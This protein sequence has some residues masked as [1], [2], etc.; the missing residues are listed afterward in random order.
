M[1]ENFRFSDERFADLQLLRYRLNGF[2]TLSTRQKAFIY[3]LSKATLSGR[4][5]TTDQFGKYN[6]LIR[7][8]LEVVLTKYEGDR[9]QAEFKRLEIYLKRLWFSNG[10][11]HHYGYEKFLP[12]FSPHFFKDI[13]KQV[14]SWLPLSEG[15]TVDEL[16]EDIFPVIFDATVLP[17]RVNKNAS[18]DIVKTS[19]CN[20][21]EQVNQQE[22]E[23]F[24]AAMKDTTDEEPPSYGL[25]SKL[26][27]KGGI[28][29]EDRWTTESLYAPAIRQIVYWLNK[30]KDYAENKHQ[31]KIIDLL[32]KY[33][34]TGD[35]RVFNAYSI[36]WLKEKEGNVDFV[37]G[38][39]E[40]YG[41][42]LGIKGSWEGIVEFKDLEA[43][44][45][46]N[47]I[48]SNA[49]WFED[50]SP[51]D[52]RFKKQIVRGVTAN[53][54][55]AAMLGGDEYP[56]SAIGINLPNAD[57]IRAK[58][59]S[60]SVTIANLIEAYNHAARGNG[61]YEEFVVDDDTLQNI[62]KYGDICDSL[63]TDLHECL[64]HGSGQL[65][66]GVDSNVLGAYGDIIEEARADLFGLYYIA[67][68]KM[69]QLELLPN[70]EAYKSQYY[71][72]MMNGLMTQQVRIKSGAQIEEAHMRNRALISNWVMEH[73]CGAV[74][75]VKRDRH[76]YIKVKDY[77]ALRNLFARLLAEIQ[78]IKSEGDYIEAKNL[79]ERYGVILDPVL[80]E[81]ILQRYTKLNISPYKGFI[82]PWMKP[83]YGHK[84]EIIDIELDYTETFEHQMLRYSK[85]YGLL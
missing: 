80:H 56:S 76:T 45:R 46:T 82:N 44:K 21:Y 33:Y 14:S 20:F 18:E 54:V 16:C 3:F 57:W 72:Y 51:V 29:T 6:L 53:V 58:Y 11:Y 47:I 71:T 78:R 4:D 55:C 69:V 30:A 77:V 60:K 41:D 83:V 68:E 50:H 43:T 12:E 85:E 66:S 39:I 40:V 9:N 17:K 23:M 37:N 32:I 73:A 64:G 79:V 84:G 2:E 25:N 49:Q 67:D 74:E 7:K 31:I 19:A 42:P 59:G 75:W 24:Y 1:Q 70:M 36:E 34:R 22:V 26:I 62:D 35:L 28:L 63:H 8:I 38:F 27:K 15:Q 81:E 48:S 13:L 10:I 65:L 61:F 5:I 52:R